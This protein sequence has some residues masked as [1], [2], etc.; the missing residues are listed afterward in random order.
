MA[1]TRGGAAEHRTN[2][3]LLHETLYKQ[4][5]TEY[6]HQM[7]TAPILI[8][9]DDPVVRHI[10]GS[11]LKSIGLVADSVE[12]GAKCVEKIRQGL[13]KSELPRLLFLDLQLTDMTGA[14]VLLQLHELLGPNKL[15]VV[16]L[17]ANSREE[18]QKSYP[19]LVADEFLEKP[20]SP[21]AVSDVV[22]RLGIS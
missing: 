7:T 17:S 21:Q 19:T 16:I 22:L 8:A 9:D 11:I 5:T 12:T 1:L 10:L 20:F 14:E 2:P 18:A 4:S 3:E 13:T 15:Q 6:I